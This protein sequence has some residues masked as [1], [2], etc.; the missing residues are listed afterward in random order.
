MSEHT[1]NLPGPRDTL[2]RAEQIVGRAE[3]QVGPFVARLVG[4]TRE[5]LEDI[6]AEVEAIRQSK[7]A[8]RGESNGHG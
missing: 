5:E 2:A 4:R 6:W 3:A 7:R 8:S 1:G